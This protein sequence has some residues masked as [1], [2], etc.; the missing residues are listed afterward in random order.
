[1]ARTNSDRY[2]GSPEWHSPKG[3]QSTPPL[4]YRYGIFAI[5]NHALHAHGGP[6]PGKTRGG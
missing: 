4:I 3:E 5:C 6:S 1:M 2:F